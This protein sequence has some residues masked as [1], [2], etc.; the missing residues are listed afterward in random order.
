[1]ASACRILLHWR[2][3]ARDGTRIRWAAV[4]DDRTELIRTMREVRRKALGGEFLVA[5]QGAGPEVARFTNA[6]AISRWPAS[7]R[8]PAEARGNWAA[9][10]ASGHARSRLLRSL[11]GLLAEA[12]RDGLLDIAPAATAADAIC[13]SLEGGRT[14]VAGD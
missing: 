12:E 10:V 14:I 11:G 8:L 5:R 7:E 3:R 1:M 2:E 6:R 4:A 13:Q 9:E